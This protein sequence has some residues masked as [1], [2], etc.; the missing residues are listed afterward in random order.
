MQNLNIDYYINEA[1]EIEKLY[2]D[3][4]NGTAKAEKRRNQY[5]QIVE[6]DFCKINKARK[7]LQ[8]NILRKYE[9]WYEVCRRIV[10]EYVDFQETDKYE[11]FVN[12]YLEILSLIDLRVTGT[13]SPRKIQLE[14]NFIKYFDI[15]LNI[16]HTIKPIIALNENNY[17]R[18]IS[19]DLLSSELD[20]AEL[21]YEKEFIRPAGIIAGIVLERYLKTLCELNEIEL[22]SKDTLYPLAQKLRTSEKVPG[23]DLVMLKSIEHLGSL[24][25]KC[26]H[27]GE[28]PKKQEVRELIDKTKKITFMAFS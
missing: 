16:L 3:L 8:R 2:G 5:N 9:V 19:A 12:Q 22:D 15:Q 21:L 18:V 1:E 14:N 20:G 7:P 13:S 11:E 24:R 23:F 10:R 28:E 27:P 26:A 6:I 4:L 25:N 17:K